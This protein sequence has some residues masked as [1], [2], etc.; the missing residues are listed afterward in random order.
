MRTPASDP[1]SLA[2]LRRADTT[3]DLARLRRAAGTLA[4]V[5]RNVLGA[6]LDERFRRVRLTNPTPA[7]VRNVLEC[8]VAAAAAAAAALPVAATPFALWLRRLGF[9]VGAGDFAL[10]EGAA[11][12]TL[13]DAAAL[14]AME[15]SDACD[16]QLAAIADRETRAALE[17][18]KAEEAR[19]AAN[20]AAA[21]ETR[22]R[23]ARQRRDV[24]AWVRDAVAKIDEGVRS[25]AAAP[26]QAAT[27]WHPIH[28]ALA[29]ALRLL[30]TPTA[31]TFRITQMNVALFIVTLRVTDDSSDSDA[32]SAARG[33]SALASAFNVL[34]ESNSVRQSSFE[35]VLDVRRCPPPSD[36]AAADAAWCVLQAAYDAID[37]VRHERAASFDAERN[38]VR[39]SIQ[40]SDA[41]RQA[42]T[43][44]I[45]LA[46][47]GPR[48]DPELEHSAV[49][50]VNDVA[51]FIE[52]CWHLDGAR[53][54]VA[55]HRI[56]AQRL[57]AAFRAGELSI[58]DLIR[59]RE[60]WSA[61]YEQKKAAR[62]VPFAA[63]AIDA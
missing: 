1:I 53:G 11:D 33:A 51:G 54:Y 26:S 48:I 59:E 29:D 35:F 13:F 34:W 49:Q 46:R 7:P 63:A 42:E 36:A 2:W 30:A 31:S 14:R 9:Q 55:T 38:S 28:A 16:A 15:L 39:A 45:A 5:C 56:E 18:H 62:G 50:V 27:V 23:F 20:D 60:R 19:R 25:D 58:A 17:Q 21:A 40:A 4:T 24:A 22:T 57:L 37:T 12:L 41:A 52:L 44:A 61:T 43:A 32:P 3:E 8:S 47:A 6:P 10:L